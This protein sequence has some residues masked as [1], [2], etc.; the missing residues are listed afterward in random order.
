MT[1]FVIGLERYGLI[2]AF[3]PFFTGPARML[4]VVLFVAF[5]I[6]ILVWMRTGIFP[7]ACIVAWLVFLPT[8]LWEKLGVGGD[9][10]SRL[11]LPRWRGLAALA[12]LGY[13]FLWNVGTVW[14]GVRPRGMW[15]AP[16]YLLRVEQRWSM[17]SPQPP[18]RT[19]YVVAR[20]ETDTGAAVDLLNGA[21]LGQIA[22]RPAGRYDRV[23]WRNYFGYVLS[24]GTRELRERLAASLGDD[25][26][27][28][29]AGQEQLTS[30]RLDFV[31]EALLAGGT[32]LL[33]DRDQRV[34]E[35]ARVPVLAAPMR[36]P[37]VPLERWFLRVMLGVSV[38]AWVALVLAELG[39]FRLGLLG[40]L[41]TAGAFGLSL[42]VYAFRE[43]PAGPAATAGGLKPALAATAGILL[44]AALFL[45]PYETAVAG[46]DATV[47][48]NFGRQIAHHG[49]LA[50]EDP[51]LRPLSTASRAELFLNRIPGD[52]TGQF[53]TIPRRLPDRRHRRPDG[54]RRLFPHCFRSSP[55]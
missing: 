15:S 37:A 28:S 51:L 49:A 45:P 24:N 12:I 3:L 40:L 34:Q 46:G 21:A 4:A 54:H 55:P 16:A 44:C 14:E 47:Y 36:G 50:F 26:N 53:C 13:V 10:A 41:L 1:R 32:D 8:W 33:T 43:G 31:S 30:V 27:S 22:R 29:R 9:V 38:V 18:S 19:R 11:R 7:V 20:G 23:R 25:W 52:R 42:L 48:L 5:H 6:G 39:Q 17:F 2:L 35:L